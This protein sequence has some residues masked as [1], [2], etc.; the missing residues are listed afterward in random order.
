MTMTILLKDSIQLGLAYRFRCLVHYH[1][2]GKYSSIHAGMVLQE[3]RVLCLPLKE[4]GS[5]LTLP[6]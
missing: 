3:L 5:R 4:A 6:H 2:G 1:P